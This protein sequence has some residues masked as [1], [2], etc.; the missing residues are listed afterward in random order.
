MM[1][2]AGV[3]SVHAQTNATATSV[4]T[5][6]KR[7]PYVQGLSSM[8]DFKGTA[9]PHRLAAKGTATDFWG[10]ETFGTGSS[11]SLPTGWTAGAFSGG[12]WKWMDVASTS[13][14]TMGAMN[15]TTAADGWMIFDSDSIGA[16]TGTAP[17]GWLQS[18]LITA[19]ATQATVRLNF[20]NF[21]R[22]F[23]DSCSVW[24]GTS[25]TF[26]PGTYSV[27]PVYYNNALATN[28][29]SPNTSHIQMNITSAAAM[30]PNIYIRFVYYGATGGS[31]SWMVD[32]MT[33]S[34]MDNYD[35]GIDNASMVYYGGSAVGWASLGAKPAHLMDTLYPVAYLSN[36]G[37]NVASATTVNAQIFQGTSNVYNQNIV[38]SLPIS[39]MDSVADFT[40]VGTPPGYFST[41]IAN[42]TVP[43]SVSVA[44]DA[45]SSNDNDTTGFSVTDS[46]WSMNAPF[47]QST[48]G[49][50]VY[51]TSP[52]LANSPATGFAMAAGMSDTISSVSVAF[53]N[54]TTAGQ[55]VGVQIY[56]F[57]GTSWLYDGTT[58]Y[59]A[60]TAA[61]IS[62]STSLVY[63]NFKIDYEGS[64]GFVIMDGSTDGVTY[65][66]VLKGKNNT[67]NVV[68]LT[69]TPP[70]PQNIVGFSAYS[71]TSYNDGGATQNFGQVGLPYANSSVPRIQLNFANIA[72]VGI[73][74]VNAVGVNIGNPTPNPATNSFYIPVTVNSERDVIYT[75]TDITGRVVDTKTIHVKSGST[76]R[77][78]SNTAALA[79][80]LY[81]YSVSSNGTVTT[82]KVSVAH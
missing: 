4:N 51:R 58:E 77:I 67:G 33:L 20:E 79:N 29:Y 13:P 60:L 25:P 75:L 49:Q 39:A 41:T 44:S 70:A 61:D 3:L 8:T 27:F 28:V 16:A 80:G 31:Y 59:R 11:S 66:A 45:N 36:Y 30:Q 68:V 5:R 62:S 2:T 48:G 24:V 50:Y 12:T 10:P 1:A 14:Y 22:K 18:P 43:F 34:S 69:T 23:N 72:P 26:T 53:D 19:C 38:T 32:D 64:G 55:V 65:A 46:V 76:T 63:A 57:D 17:S 40:A 56:H 74:D 81:V 7:T 82:G 73:A 6:T 21:F 42:Y 9:A 71:D 37:A 15:S 52:L 78:T 35:A 47:A 54:T